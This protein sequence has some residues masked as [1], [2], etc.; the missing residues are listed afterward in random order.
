MQRR[1]SII[2]TEGKPV[3]ANSDAPVVILVHPQLGENIGACARAMAN[4]S[5]NELRLVSPRDGWP[6]GRAMAAASGAGAIV[7]AAQ[8]FETLEE[9]IADVNVVLATTARR[10]DMIK[11]VLTPETAAVESRAQIEAGKRVALVFGP[12]RT[13]LESDHIALADKLVMAPVNPKFASINLAQ[14]VLLVGYE[15]YK[16]SPEGG[17]LGRGT[18]MEAAGQEG[19]QL[20]ATRPATKQELVIFFDRLE[21]ELDKTSYFHPPEKS[22]SMRRNLRNIFSRMELTERELRMLH[23]VISAFTLHRWMPKGE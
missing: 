4:F 22:P 7:E 12:E 15:W 18:Q 16:Q 9:S 14:A 23:G 10:R 13:G 11:P 19:L 1:V 20:V 2:S 6:N 21:R 3:V 17:G 5:L 8:V